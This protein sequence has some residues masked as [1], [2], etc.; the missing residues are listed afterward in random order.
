M[1]TLH[2]RTAL[3]CLS[4]SLGGL[5]LSTL[6]LA[7]AMSDRGVP[8][9]VVVPPSTPIH[10]RAIELSLN[11]STIEPRWKY[12]DFSAAARLATVLT[13]NSIDL[14]I[15]M[16]S[17]D[18]HLAS[19]ATRSSPRV[20][21][22]FYQQMNSRHNKRDLLH[23]W[24]YSKLSL[25]ISLTQGMRE[26]VLTFTRMPRE[27]V[28]VLPL[29]ADLHQF[30]PAHF[31]KREARAFF[32]LPSGKKI[33]GVLGRLDP[34]KGQEILLRAVPEVMKKHR[35]VLFVIAGDETAGEQGYKAHLEDVCRAFA[36]EPY[37]KFLPF[38]DDVPHL[39]AALDI[40]ALPSFSETFGLVVVEAMAME[41]PIIATNAGGLPEIITNGKTGLLIEPRDANAV[42]RAI[43][44]VLSDNV[45]RISLAHSARAEAVRRYS[46]EI[47]VDAL[48]GSL[49]AI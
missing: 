11:L 31:T 32:G 6:R 13:N 49:A 48:L 34:Q 24:I 40:F 4:R 29:G 27:K 25:W 41:R 15:L 3:V 36:I 33:I 19:L 47:C 7:K 12:G 42:A 43:H 23:T 38:T 45:L 5:E 46:L 17:Q 20:K 14:V 28:K 10:R 16:Q 26:D 37:V 44:R 30:N 9:M 21:L 35:D 1:D 18:I 2:K 39:M 8:T 22:V